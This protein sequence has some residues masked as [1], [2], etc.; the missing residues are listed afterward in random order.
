MLR[1]RL[2]PLALA[3]LAYSCGGGSGDSG[4]TTSPKA[5]KP[6]Q[7]CDF[8]VNT[9]ND[10][11][12]ANPGDG[13]CADA[14]NNCSLRAA[15]M[16]ANALG[17]TKVIC[18][19]TNQTYT[20]S[21][22]TAAGDDNTA[23]EDDLDINTNNNNANITIEG[24]GSTVQR[25]P[26]LTCN[27]DYTE[28]VGE[29]RI[30]HVLSGGSLTLK[31]L[32]VR[33]GCADG[34]SGGGIYNDTNG[35]LTITNSTISGNSSVGDGGGISNIGTLDIQNSIISN[36]SAGRDGGGI[37]SSGI[38]TSIFVNIVNSTISNNSADSDGG[39]IYNYTNSYMTI[40]GSTISNNS[41][42]FDGGGIVNGGTLTIQNSTI[43]G[44][45]SVGDGGGI[46]NW[47]GTVNASF[48]TIAN[49]TANNQGG[50][51]YNL[52]TF[53]IKNS[54][55]ANNTVGGSPQNCYID[56]GST[57]TPS[58]VN[59]ANDN[60]CTG[61]TQVTSAQLNLQPLG[62]YGGPTQ[63]I[64]LG[65]GSVAIDAVTDCT[66]LSSNPVNTDQRGVSRPQGTQCDA[67]AYEYNGPP[68]TT[69][70]LSI[71]PTPTNGNVTSSPGGINCGSSGS[72]CSDNFTS[73]TNV[74][75]TAT[76]DSGYTFAGWGGDC[77]SCGTN[78]TCNITMNA[79]KTCS[80]NFTA[81][82]GGGGAETPPNLSNIT[83]P[84]FG[85]RD[86]VDF[87]N[88][89]L[90]TRKGPA[91][92]RIES[93]NVIFISGIRINELTGA[94]QQQN[95]IL[96][97]NAG[98]RPCGAQQFNLS[99]YCTVGIIFEPKSEGKKEAFLEVYYNTPNPVRIY[100]TGTGV[101][102]QSQPQP[103]PSPQPP[104]AGGGGSSGGSGSSAGTG[105]GGGGCSMSS[106]GSPLNA[107]AWLM[108]PGAAL[109][110]RLRRS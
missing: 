8:T 89:A 18:L 76:P 61:F 44:N 25:D 92:I 103:Q 56:A 9:T 62:N 79:N 34:L 66:D 36:N 54:I 95:F 35:T 52:D 16:E 78:T 110:R 97:L 43:A 31:D 85:N 19:G 69:Y 108:L 74:Q 82:S 38:F 4:S 80:A 55:V 13:T 41:A 42:G 67:G 40:I 53:N 15:I 48:V 64:A 29:F 99:G 104:G 51:I 88:V 98:E 77:S 101:S 84:E 49:N 17:G 94:L 39:G 21:I 81:T 24:N 83:S 90:L 12:D 26:S 63:T 50:G 68:P 22:D 47:T 109:L 30:F 11:V 6:M 91:I 59:F 5:L 28:Q 58:G 46:E 102:Q 14:S 100:I 105:G 106:G 75:L 72:T 1:R 27:L 86:M 93:Q 60:T 87:K 7:T 45:S 107:L 33:N 71:S 3:A 70:T 65:T 2:L 10:T 20:L 37:F 73:G 23:A 96:D 57:F 32:T